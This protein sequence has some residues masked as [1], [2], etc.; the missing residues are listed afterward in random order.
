MKTR[1]QFILS[2]FT[3]F[4]LG[5]LPKMQA[6]LPPEIPGNPD[7][8]YPAFTTAEGCNALSLLGSG[9]GN[10][11]VGW[12]SLFLV[13]DASF[14]TG[15]GAGALALT[16]TGADSNTAVGTAAMLL[17]TS[18]TQNVAIGTD[19]LLFNDN[20]AYNNAVGAF[21]LFNNISGFSNNAFGNSALFT[22]INGFENTA[23]GDLA[24][25]NNDITGH[26]LASFNTGVGA[27]ALNGNT[28]GVANTAV[29]AGA[30]TSNDTGSV[31]TAVGVGA[32]NSNTDGERNTAV[33]FDALLNLAMGI[34]NIALG[35]GAGNSITG[36]SFN[37][38]IG[39]LGVGPI[40][41]V[42]IRIGDPTIHKSTYIAG[43]SG[44]TASGGMAVYVN[45]DGKLGTSPSS[46]RFKEDI[47]PMDKASE[48]VFALKPVTFRYKKELDPKSIPQ[49][50]LIAEEVEKV[51]P[52]LVVRDKEG[53]PYA[54]RYEQINAMLLNEFLKEH[55]TVQEQQK[56]ID[57]LRNELKEQRVLIQKVS[58]QV[59][60]SNPARQVV[61]SNQ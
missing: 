8:C 58:A 12:Y 3:L 10:T 45:P 47:Q 31:N 46:K 54:V 34:N 49:F 2:V 20:G 39:N 13:G 26:S 11:G 43:I 32:L 17:N 16:T 55:R 52:D 40:E 25:A 6:A 9:I 60:M 44:A 41:A 57:A 35:V 4:F 50:G 30:L 7:G 23:I 53:K 42:T 56:E 38:Y 15:V 61:I 48:A 36:G 22:N 37:I 21:A 33:G 18:G 19:A 1:I 5:L 51:D 28:D 29:G 24:L 14:N 59:E 27:A